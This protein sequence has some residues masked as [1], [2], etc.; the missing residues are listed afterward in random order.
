MEIL[1][2]ER[3]RHIFNVFEIAEF[4]V[5][6]DELANIV[7]NTDIKTSLIN[8]HISL[9]FSVV[10]YRQR[11]MCQE[12]KKFYDVKFLKWKFYIFLTRAVQQCL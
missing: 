12:M 11:A 10:Q 5:K 7:S 8:R 9:Y 2:L 4:M 1:V 3:T 6:T